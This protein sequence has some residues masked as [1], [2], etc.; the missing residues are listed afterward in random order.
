ML[1]G[2]DVQRESDVGQKSDLA[3]LDCSIA[4]QGFLLTWYLH[5]LGPPPQ[6]GSSEHWTQAPMYGAF[7]TQ[8]HPITLVAG[9]V[10]EW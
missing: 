5:Q 9:L 1:L 10:D 6:K 8:D 7:D 2:L 3:L 4:I